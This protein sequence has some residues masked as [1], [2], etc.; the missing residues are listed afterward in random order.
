MTVSHEPPGY[1]CPFCQ[2]AAGLDTAHSC[3]RDIVRRLPGAIAF[4]SPR[5]WPRNHGNVLVV[6]C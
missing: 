3:Q 1:Q 2:L 4:I 5:W 6:E